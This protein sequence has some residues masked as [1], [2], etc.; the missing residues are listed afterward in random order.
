MR[1]AL[2]SMRGNTAQESTNVRQTCGSLMQHNC[3]WI[4]LDQTILEA[5][6]AM[7][8]HR[9]GFLPVCDQGKKAI[10][11][12]TDRDIVTRVVAQEVSLDQKV[13]TVASTALLTCDIGDDIQK[14]LAIMKHHQIQR[15][16]CTDAEGNLAG[17]LGLA[18]LARNIDAQQI[19]AAIAF[20]KGDCAAV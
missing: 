19:K 2:L 15:I 18:T 9:V 11:V 10:G 13:G 1:G 7:H 4:D 16:I 3:A 17:V 8:Q 14:A 20:V 6:K 12:L 5:A